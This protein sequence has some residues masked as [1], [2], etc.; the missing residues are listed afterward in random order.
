MLEE[1]AR[2][3]VRPKY[4]Y[5]IPTVQNPTGYRAWLERRKELLRL[6]RH[7]GVPVFE[8]ECYADLLWEGEWPPALRGLDWRRAGD[9]HRLLLE[10]VGPGTSARLCQRPGR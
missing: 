10:V 6:S 2:Q 8:D 3:G 4:I 9:P 7:Y 1:L 5:T